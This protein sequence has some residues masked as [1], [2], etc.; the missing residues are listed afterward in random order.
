MFLLIK[1][2]LKHPIISTEQKFPVTCVILWGTASCREK[3]RFVYFS[4]TLITRRQ[5]TAIE[6]DKAETNTMKPFTATFHLSSADDHCQNFTTDIIE[7]SSEG[8]IPPVPFSSPPAFSS[9]LLSSA[10]RCFHSQKRV[11]A[12][13][14]SARMR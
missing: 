13:K 3:R 4:I 5:N 8:K 14:C 1:A 7:A 9:T 10:G 2:R 11:P 12:H 6:N